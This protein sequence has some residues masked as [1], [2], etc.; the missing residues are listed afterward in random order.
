MNYF[1][2]VSSKTFHSINIHNVC[3][4]QLHSMHIASAEHQLTCL[5]MF[6]NA[7]KQC[8]NTDLYLYY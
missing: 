4:N 3:N 7:R 8:R 5:L 1:G 6:Y 2:D